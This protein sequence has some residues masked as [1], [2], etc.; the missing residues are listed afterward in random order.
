M[1]ELTFEVDEPFREAFLGI[2][3]H[4]PD[5]SYEIIS[6]SEN[7]YSMPLYEY[8]VS[9]SKQDMDSLLTL[10]LAYFMKDMSKAELRETWRYVF[11]LRNR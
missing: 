10:W 1:K 5:M 11:K 2:L 3:S 4:F 6:T 8:A 7:K 9:G